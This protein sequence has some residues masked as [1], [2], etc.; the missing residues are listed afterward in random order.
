MDLMFGWASVTNFTISFNNPKV[1]LDYA[2]TALAFYR[3]FI[4][5]WFS[6][7]IQIM[8]PLIATGQLLMAIGMFLKGWWVNAAC[9]GAVIFL[10]AIAPLMAG[11]GFPF[12]IVVSL[13]AWLVF[14]H[15][16]KDYLWRKH[17]N[18]SATTK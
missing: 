4:N 11:S 10:L 2:D 13:A 1:Y 8:V 17:P 6:A 14:K 5:G 7:H 18:L 3:D 16:A 15:D 9:I 12:S